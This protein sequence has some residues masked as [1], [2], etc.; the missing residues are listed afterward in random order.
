MAPARMSSATSA[1]R[2]GKWNGGAELE[3][4][5]LQ[6]ACEVFAEDRG[7]LLEPRSLGDCA[8]PFCC[9]A[10]NAKACVIPK[11]RFESAWSNQ[12][13]KGAP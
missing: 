12:K 9:P 1:E 13:P 2:P 3:L 7:L 8:V 11:T 4:A 10:S 5:Q 6:Q